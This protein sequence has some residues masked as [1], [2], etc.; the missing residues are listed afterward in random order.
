M[1]A[2]DHENASPH[3]ITIVLSR[4]DFLKLSSLSLGVL[5]ARPAMRWLSPQPPYGRPG[6]RGRVAKSSINIHSQPDP[7]S[8]QL[9][10]L[11][12]DTILELL[13]EVISPD[14]P[15]ENPRWYL[16][17]AGFVHSAYIQRVDYAHLNPPL[18]SVLETGQIGEVS[19]PVSQSIYHNRAGRWAPLYRLYYKSQHWITGVW[20]DERDQTWYRL[21]DDWLKVTYH[22]RAETIRPLSPGEWQPTSPNVPAAEKRIEVSLA[23]QELT[24]FETGQP[25]F[26]AKVST[27]KRYMETPRGEFSVNRKY[28]GKHMGFGALTDNPAAYELVGVPW[29]SFFHTTGVAFHGTYWHDNFGAPMSHGCVNLQVED[30]RW[31]FRWCNPPFPAA[32]N[33]R[34]DWVVRGPGTSV[35]IY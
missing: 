7:A 17:A 1:I 6:M 10:K 23:G 32:I 5:A 16:V 25:V 28:P 24:A 34:K 35:K 21:V 13:E 30:A 4:R 9:G 27:G 3:R 14:G 19:I 12:R 33:S 18:S 11:P 29:V 31:L 8:K 2:I 26:Q 22:A 20:K 15:P